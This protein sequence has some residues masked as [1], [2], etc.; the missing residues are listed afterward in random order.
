MRSI[1]KSFVVTLLLFVVCLGSGWA[2]A[3]SAGAASAV[4][5]EQIWQAYLAD[6]GAQDATDAD[7]ALL[8]PYLQKL[9]ET[10]GDMMNAKV[11]VQSWM[12]AQCAFMKNM[13]DSGL[14]E[15]L[16]KLVPPEQLAQ[17]GGREEAIRRM[18][19]ELRTMVEQTEQLIP[20][21]GDLMRQKNIT[22]EQLFLQMGL[23]EAN[24]AKFRNHDLTIADILLTQPSLFCP[25]GE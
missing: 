9:P 21:I 3:L 1:K 8:K 6:P 22:E 4:T 25:S 11:T 23:N 19:L 10:L 17:L 13:I 12:K 5:G 7:K 14:V 18:T 16:V 15:E 2:F 20:L 24:M